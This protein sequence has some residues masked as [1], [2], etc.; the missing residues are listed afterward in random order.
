[1]LMMGIIE[2]GRILFIY[3]SVGAAAREASRYGAGVG[4]AELSEVPYKDCAGIR[5]A[6]QRIGQMAGVNAADLASITIQ[7]DHGPSTTNWAQCSGNTFNPVVV[8][9]PFAK[10]G[11][12]VIVSVSINYSPVVPLVPFP[13]FK[14]S[15]KNA[16]TIVKQVTIAPAYP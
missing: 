10:L 5:Q 4:S 1:M 11:D 16:H 7:Y 14:I 2:G 6:A 12:R 13:S 9:Q 8:D 3:S 15:G